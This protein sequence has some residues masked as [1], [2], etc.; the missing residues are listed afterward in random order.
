MISAVTMGTDTGALKSRFTVEDYPCWDILCVWVTAQIRI[1]L[2][3]YCTDYIVTNYYWH[4]Q[5]F[6]SQVQIKGNK[7]VF[8]DASPFS[9]MPCSFRASPAHL[10][11]SRASVLER[12]QRLWSPTG[13]GSSREEYRLHQS[14]LI[15]PEHHS[16]P[17]GRLGMPT[18]SD[19]TSRSW[20]STSTT[21]SS[22]RRWLI[23]LMSGMAMRRG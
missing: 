3:Q 16:P 6:F 15:T 2:A 1:P 10:A 19:V 20:R 8:R 7:P 11:P 12:L 18:G 9:P 5:L 14:I 13:E 22:R 23:H 4:V 17:I 21:G